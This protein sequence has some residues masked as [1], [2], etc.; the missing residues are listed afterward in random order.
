MANGII[1]V[2]RR[3]G[4]DVETVD[5]TESRKEARY[6]VQEYNL[7]GPSAH[8]YTSQRACVDWG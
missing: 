5:E 2:N 3:D 7:A 4:R 6:M 1:Y 8:Y